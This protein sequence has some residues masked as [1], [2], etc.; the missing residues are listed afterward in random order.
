MGR[1]LRDVRAR[2]AGLFDNRFKIGRS[3]VE[4]VIRRD[5][6]SAIELA[7]KLVVDVDE[8]GAVPGGSF[9]NSA[10]FFNGTLEETASIHSPACCDDGNGNA[11]PAGVAGTLRFLQIVQPDFNAVCP[12]DVRLEDLIDGFRSERNTQTSGTHFKMPSSL[13][14]E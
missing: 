5:H 11:V 13:R 6:F 4:I 3:V 1:N 2:G 7:A 14:T 10:F 9:Q 8:F 12:G